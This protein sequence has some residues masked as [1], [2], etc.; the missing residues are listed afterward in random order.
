MSVSKILTT[1]LGIQQFSIYA[2]EGLFTTGTWYCTEF[3][4]SA[5]FQK[6][7]TG[8]VTKLYKN[9]MFAERSCLHSIKELKLLTLQ[10]RVCTLQHGN[11]VC[12][13]KHLLV[14][15]CAWESSWEGISVPR[16]WAVLRGLNLTLGH[17]CHLHKDLGPPDK[18]HHAYVWCILY[19]PCIY[20]YIYTCVNKYRYLC[21][22]VCIELLC[23]HTFT[24]QR[25]YNDKMTQPQLSPQPSLNRQFRIGYQYMGGSSKRYR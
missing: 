4:P 10:H 23:M 19:I 8:V 13:Q 14:A 18:L 3:P 11:K 17:D 7:S 12:N 20:I 22:C 9:D 15:E 1:S 2:L 16:E 24:K 25:N 6:P 5:V 21:V